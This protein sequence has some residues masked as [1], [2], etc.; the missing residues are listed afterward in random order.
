MSFK[1]HTSDFQMTQEIIVVCSILGDC[2]THCESNGFCNAHRIGKIFE[3]FD[4]RIQIKFIKIPNENIAKIDTARIFAKRLF[5]RI[6]YKRL[7]LFEVDARLILIFIVMDILSKRCVQ[8]IPTSVKL[9]ANLYKFIIDVFRDEIFER[10]FEEVCTKLTLLKG[11]N[12][13]VIIIRKVICII[14]RIVQRCRIIHPLKSSCC[15]K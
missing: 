2:I 4:L 8:I 5:E 3:R 6:A 15:S 7:Y 12:Q 11:I 14:N 10:F 9:I 1:R 13:F